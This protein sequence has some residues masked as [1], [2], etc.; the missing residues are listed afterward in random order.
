MP[1]RH[2]QKKLRIKEYVTGPVKIG[3]VGTNY[4][5]SHNRTYLNAG[6]GYL[7]SITIKYYKANE[8]LNKC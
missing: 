8:I 6:I 3:H 7:H 2:K 1:F 4:T 5:P